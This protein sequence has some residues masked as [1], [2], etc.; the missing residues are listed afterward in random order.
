MKIARSIVNGVAI[1]ALGWA[2]AQ[3][4]ASAFQLTEQNSSG[5]G[6]AYAGQA[7]AAENASTIFYNPAGMTYLPG[8][9]V[10]ANLSAI[11]PTFE[12]KD[13]GGSRSPAGLPEPAGGDN[14]GNAG[15]W[16]YL[17]TG[18]FS[19]QLT[20]KL[21]TGLG[22]T[23]PFGL[24]T[25]YDPTFI[26]RY[27]SQRADLKTVDINPSVAYR[28][29]DIVSLGGGVSY[30][31]ARLGF[32]RLFFAGAS[33]QETLS[34]NDSAWGWNAGAMFDFGKDTRV[35]LTYRSSMSYTLNGTITI[36][37]LGG[38]NASAHLAMPETVSAALSHRFTDKL[39]LL[40]DVTWTRWSRIQ[41]VQIVLA[42]PIGAIPAG[43]ADTLDLQFRN[44][45]RVGLGLNYRWTDKLLLKLG[46]AYDQT[47]IQSATQR[48]TY[49]PDN[50]RT[51]LAIGAT[52]Y[53]T[54][55]DTVDVGYAHLFVS[56]PDMQRNKGVGFGGAQGIV[57][58][59]AS[60]S[61]DIV[62]IGYTHTF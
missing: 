14:G 27:Q 45:F 9:Q 7:A 37:G 3:V 60:V 24:K 17:P 38:S 51:W 55:S 33:L 20:P 41:N 48:P 22:I 46:V 11:R 43:P 12:F 34:V 56:D 18:Y 19:W 59:S 21:W 31:H 8:K 23:A 29:N 36:A 49:L 10:N 61:V 35:G 26:G 6:N 1:T 2:P 58:G 4:L 13:N 30:Q 42:S 47:P 32:D 39:Q 52:H 44:T 16:N 53:L 57:S 54:K 50:N 15:D 5:L 40:G 28:I 25:Q 62:N